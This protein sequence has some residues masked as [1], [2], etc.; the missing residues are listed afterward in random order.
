MGI[1]INN[2]GYT[3]NGKNKGKGLFRVS[4][5]F[6]ENDLALVVKDAEKAGFRRVVVPVKIQKPHGLPDEWLANTDGVGRFL[7]NCYD[8]WK[9]TAPE[10]LKELA[11][12]E[13]QLKELSAK[14]EALEK[15][16]A[17]DRG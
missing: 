14:K 15:G 9:K 8:Y 17:E 1:L 4:I 16:I 2:F 7:K 5:Y 11:E 6:N 13:R 12:T 10:R 3:M